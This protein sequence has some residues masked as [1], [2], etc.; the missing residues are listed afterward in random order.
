M[1]FVPFDEFLKQVASVTL[2]S[3]RQSHLALHAA[4]GAPAEFESMRK[5][6]LGLYRGV[7]VAH[8]FVT[9]DG[10]HVDCIPIEQQPTLRHPALKGH[11][12]QTVP[13]PNPAPAPPPAGGLQGPGTPMGVTPHLVK[14][15]HDEYGNE[16]FC[17]EG[18][19]PMR[20]LTLEEM[21][22]FKT[23]KE[24]FRKSPGGD[25]HPGRRRV[26]TPPPD[27]HDGHRYATALQNVNCTGGSSYLNIWNPTTVAGGMSLSQQWYS[28]GSFTDNT[29]QTVEGGWQVLPSKYGDSATHL[30]IYWTADAYQHTGCYNLDCQAFVQ[31]DHTWI[32]GGSIGPVSTSGGSQYQINMQWKRD[33]STGNWWLYLQG[34]GSQTAVGYYPHALY[35]TGPMAS[36]ATTIEFGGEVYGKPT[37]GQMGSGA[38][39]SAGWQKAAYQRQNW[40]INTGGTSEWTSLTGDEP[41]P[42]CY[43]EQIGTNGGSDWVVYFFFGGP[44]CG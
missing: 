20:R 40:Y 4:E 18:T 42:T 5:H 36:N 22:R 7:K 43:T 26:K 37:S 38:F 11:V 21:T 8:T 35:G 10:H 6:I 34:S 39:A 1:P 3:H 28:G 25:G 14:G 23:L 27:I 30:F 16:M 13:P 19:I 41:D 31:V 2:D 32:L 44:S 15:K 17:P 12:I 29:I 33:S 24:F 9:A